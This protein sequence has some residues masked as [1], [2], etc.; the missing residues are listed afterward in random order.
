MLESSCPSRF[1]AATTAPERP[2]IWPWCAL[3]CFCSCPMFAAR[4]ARGRRMKVT[5]ASNARTA[6]SA[7]QVALLVGLVTLSIDELRGPDM[8]STD[9]FFPAPR[10]SG[11]SKR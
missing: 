11:G 9:R 2:E 1:E 6:R 3:I 7:A 10:G 5:P 4:A 8:A